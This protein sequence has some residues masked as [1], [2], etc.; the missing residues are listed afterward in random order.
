MTNQEFQTLSVDEIKT[1]YKHGSFDSIRDYRLTSKQVTDL[2][3]G[4]VLEMAQ[5]GI[6]HTE[7]IPAYI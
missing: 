2:P 4:L 1:L 6:L 5:K 7:P 3:T